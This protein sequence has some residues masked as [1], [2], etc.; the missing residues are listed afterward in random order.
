MTPLDLHAMMLRRKVG[1]TPERQESARKALKAAITSHVKGDLLNAVEE[2]W[3][4]SLPDSELNEASVAKLEYAIR[5]RIAEVLQDAIQ[6]CRAAGLSETDLEEALKV[7]KLLDSLVL[8]TAA[9]VSNKD[10]ELLKSII[11]E[12]QAEGWQGQELQQAQKNEA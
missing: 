7:Q 9:A 11:E 12:W 3:Y 1:E 4:A 10:L 2:G 5:C 8:R 6:E